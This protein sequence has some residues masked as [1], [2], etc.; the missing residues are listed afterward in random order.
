MYLNNLLICTWFLLSNLLSRIENLSYFFCFVGQ[1]MRTLLISE[2]RGFFQHK[3]YS[4]TLNT[5]ERP[6]Y[7]YAIGFALVLYYYIFTLTFFEHYNSLNIRS[8]F[9]K[10]KGRIEHKY[11]CDHIILV[12][13][14]FRFEILKI[15]YILKNHVVHVTLLKPVEIETRNFKG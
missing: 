6:T 4:F 1:L 13:T 9:T 8:F 5:N 15:W 11:T 14:S 10:F 7:C 3:L 12:M 2:F